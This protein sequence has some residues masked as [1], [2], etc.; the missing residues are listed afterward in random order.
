MQ[1]IGISGKEWLQKMDTYIQQQ[2][3]CFPD[4]VYMLPQHPCSFQVHH[5]PMRMQ[6]TLPPRFKLLGEGLVQT[7]D[8]TVDFEPL[9]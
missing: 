9:P 7:A 5:A 4:E 3:R 1:E 2:L 8:G 6:E